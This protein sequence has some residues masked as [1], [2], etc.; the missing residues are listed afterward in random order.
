[1]PG[2][3]SWPLLAASF[4][5]AMG[6][7]S[8]PSGPSIVVLGIA[9]DG[10]VPQAGSFSDPRWDA[11]S[12]SRCVACLGVF[13]PRTGQ[14]WMIDATPD[15]KQQLLALYRIGGGPPRPVVNGIF[16]THAHIGHYTG[17]MFLGHE[18]MGAKTI[19]VYTMP[20]MKEFL[21]TN[22]PWEQMVQYENI[23]LR[24]LNNGVPVQLADDIFIEPI[25]VPHRQEY[26]E[27]VGFRIRGANGSVLYIPDI[28]AW[29]EWD[30]QGVR[31]EDLIASVDVAYLDGTFF[32]NGELGG[33]DMTGFP[34]P[35]ISHSLHRFSALPASERGK[36]RFIHLNHSNP[37][38][39][40]NSDARQSIEAAGMHVADEGELSRL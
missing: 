9:Q 26:S 10:G 17:L 15:F 19:P 33:R 35:F 37:A 32:A 3:K 29:E 2:M 8:V 34:H 31:V 22:G 28:D 6:C 21:S 23:E 11:P 4:W 7:A 13:D 36:I 27:V 12:E 25:L 39:N 30:A 16:L 38:L 18:S 14:R 24:D 40:A 20:R 1:M 5:F